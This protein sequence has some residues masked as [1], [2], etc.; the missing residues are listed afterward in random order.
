MKRFWGFVKKEFYHIFRD[1]RTML[2]LFGLP[3]VQILI[4]GYVI[5]NEIKDVKIAVLDHSKD[6]N[7][8]AITDRLLSSGYFLLEQNLTNDAQIDAIFKEGDVKMVVVFGSE[9]TRR[10][11]RGGPADIQLLAD[12]SDPNMAGLLVGYSQQIVHD[13]FTEAT[14]GKGVEEG[15]Q[16][17]TR[18]LFNED[19]KGAYMY[20][21]GTMAMILI[22][23]SA[24]MTSISIVREKEMG[25]ME[26][27]LVS[28]LRPTQIIFGKVTPY[29]AL[30]VVNAMVIIALGYFVFGVPVRGS[31]SLL[32][33]ETMLYILM[34]LSLGILI[35]TLTQT[36]QA[37]MFISIFS[38]MLPTML[39]SG[40]IFPIENMPLILQWISYVMPAKYYI[41]ILKA[42]MLKGTGFLW[43]WKETLVL[44]GMTAIFIILSVK[45]FKVRLQ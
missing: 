1:S 13:Y 22:L 38:L 40:F 19:L 42:V 8:R 34:G 25:T 45:R 33:A 24:M 37:A 28:P 9:F 16:M 41:V 14:F 17:R 5:T 31:L 39:L 20:V 10:L 4:F 12:A 30:S 23:L 6:V 7:T 11:D 2:V 29:V 35:S 32:M 15:L 26:G 36:Q 3:I 21:P 18:M 43:I 44:G 27:L